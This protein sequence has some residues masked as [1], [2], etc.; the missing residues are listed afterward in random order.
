MRIVAVTVYLCI[1]NW[2]HILWS[3]ADS[4]A[5]VSV[6]MAHLQYGVTMPMADLQS[7]FGQGF[8]LGSG[9][10][11]LSNHLYIGLE[12]QFMFGNRVK[13]D[14]L[15]ALRTQEGGIIGRDMQFANIFLRQRAHHTVI[16]VGYFLQSQKS[17][18][19]MGLLLSAGAGFLQHKIRIVD[20][21]DSAIQVQ[22]PYD[23]GY[24]RLS[25]GMSLHQSLKFIYLSS[26]RLINFFVALELVEGF[27]KDRRE[28]NYNLTPISPQMRHDLLATF[29][30]GWI[31]PL[32]F[33]QG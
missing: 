18:H 24:D 11:W 13:E 5:R 17:K 30:L 2:G 14:V 8:Q 29:R 21:F 25:T 7:R 10:S 20:D 4:T 19:N 31:V 28:I 12:H 6:I 15:S 3:Q 33:D 16:R 1:S 26:S 22:T 27:I 23:K 32:Y 9:I